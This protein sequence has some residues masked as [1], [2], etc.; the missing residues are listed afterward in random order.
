MGV[1]AE[2]NR[3]SQKNDSM[4]DLDDH[5]RK[6]SG[7]DLFEHSPPRSRVSLSKNMTC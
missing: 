4:Y 3:N 2:I 6:K 7:L 5:M 1:L